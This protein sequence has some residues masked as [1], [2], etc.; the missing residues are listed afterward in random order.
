MKTPR[1]TYKYIC[2][3]CGEPTRFTPKERIRKGGMKCSA[4]G[5]RM[6]EPSKASNARHNLPIHHDIK[7]AWNDKYR[8]DDKQVNN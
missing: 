2:L 7:E 6:L 5:S 4:C 8:D 1:F 3:E